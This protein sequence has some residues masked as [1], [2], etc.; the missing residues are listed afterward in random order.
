M[1]NL[2]AWR[3]LFFPFVLVLLAACVAQHRTPAPEKK[4]AQ[5]K[6]E[7]AGQVLLVKEEGFLFWTSPGIYALEKQNGAWKEV[8][9]PMPAVIGRN[10]FAPPGEKREG[11]G[12]TPSGLYRMGT[13]FGYAASVATRMP[14]R[15]ALADDLWVDDARAPDYNRWVKHQDTKAASYERMKRD[16]DQYKYGLVIEYNTTPVIPGHGSAIFLH[17]W[18]KPGWPTA[19]CIAVSEDDLLKILG[20][21]NPARAPIIL[22]NPD[23]N[24]TGGLLP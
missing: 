14:Y 11:D 24:E 1:K 2:K 15:Q 9:E 5:E 6:M 8:F 23:K 20:W 21:L 19:G 13:A 10:G 16:D 3:L 12:R 7:T 17:V 22:I 18:K 4:I